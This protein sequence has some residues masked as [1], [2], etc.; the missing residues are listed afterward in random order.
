MPST[1][2]SI[3]KSASRTRSAVGRVPP[4]GARSRR[5]PSV[6]ATTLTRVWS[7]G[8]VRSSPPGRRRIRACSGRSRSGSSAAR[9]PATLSRAVE[10]FGVVGE[11]RHAEL[12]QAV[13]ARSEHLAG[14]AK[15]QVHLG[16]PEAVPLAG[17]RP[18]ARQLGVAE[19]DA[20]RRVRAAPDPPPELVELGEAVALGRLDH[21]DR[22]VRDV[23]PHLDHARGHEHVGV[24]G[25]ERAPSRSP[26]RAACICPWISST[27][28]SRNSVRAS[29]SASLVAALAWSASDSDTSGHTT[30]H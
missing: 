2:P 17:D 27:R 3:A 15:L 20:E 22:G 21:H 1:G 28:W 26:C 9:R 8:P 25:G 29:R 23:D 18:Q 30:K 11:P 14:A 7:P 19:Q 24:A 6:P 5:P 4:A 13:L 12:R 10:Q 16:Q